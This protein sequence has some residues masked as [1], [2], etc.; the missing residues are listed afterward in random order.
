MGCLIPRSAQE[1][2]GFTGIELFQG[3]TTGTQEISEGIDRGTTRNVVSFSEME[4]K[5]LL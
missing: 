5:V 2:E 4:S 3:T 1:Q